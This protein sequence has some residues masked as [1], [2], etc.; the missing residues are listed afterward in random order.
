MLV[1]AFLLLAVSGLL[2]S[3]SGFALTPLA[4]DSSLLPMSLIVIATI[5]MMWTLRLWTTMTRRRA[6]GAL[7]IS[8]SAAMVIG[9]A[10]LEGMFRREGVF[11]RTSKTGG[12]RYGLRDALRMSRWEGLLAA[13]LYAAA[14][15]LASK[16]HPPLL[17]IVIVSIQGTVFACAPIAA[18][19]SLRTHRVPAAEFRR[20][21]DERLRPARPLKRRSLVRLATAVIIAAILG[22]SIASVAAPSQLLP[23]S[24]AQQVSSV[25]PERPLPHQNR[26]VRPLHPAAARHGASSAKRSQKK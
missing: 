5:C 17:L 19:W 26:A 9:I 13:A 3:G 4:G 20:R 7:M 21:Y 2:I 24:A 16:P 25:Q 15:L 18:V 6:L 11:L 8:W 12:R 23:V 10:C 14:A 1:F 22:V